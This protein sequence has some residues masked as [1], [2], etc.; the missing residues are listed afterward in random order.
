LFLAARYI[1]HLRAE[2][3]TEDAAVPAD[4]V[5]ALASPRLVVR[6]GGRSQFLRRIAY[7]WCGA[8]LDTRVDTLLLPVLLQVRD[9]AVPLEALLN[10]RNFEFDWGLPDGFF[11][12]RLSSGACLVMLDGLEEGPLAVENSIAAY[13][14]CRYIVAS[15]ADSRNAGSGEGGFHLGGAEACCV[16]IHGEGV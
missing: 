11:P 6:G 5:E 10:R 9:L 14:L 4:A 15:G 1:R 8:L 13:P 16:V 7:L 3:V 2:T 12:E